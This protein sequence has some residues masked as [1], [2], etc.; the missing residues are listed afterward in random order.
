MKIAVFGNFSWTKACIAHFIQRGHEVMLFFPAADLN[1]YIFYDFD[2]LP[3]PVMFYQD[4]KD[5]RVRYN[6]QAFAPDYL[7]SII[8]DKKVPNSIIELASQMALN[9]HPAKLPEFR[10]GNAWYWPVRLG[11]RES[12][13]TIHKLTDQWDQGDIVFQESFPLDP[14]ET[15][16][17][18][19]DKV[20]RLTP[21]LISNFDP[22][23]SGHNLQTRPQTGEARYFFKP[24]DSDF[25]IHWNNDVDDID[26]LI[27]ASYPYYIARTAWRK[28]Y[29]GIVEA[30]PTEEPAKGFPGEV[31]VST[32]DVSVNCGGQRLLI[33]RFMMFDE[34]VFPA[35][36]FIRR[37]SLKTGETF[38]SP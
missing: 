5:E 13:V 10:S 37:Y 1:H 23:L 38:F 24:K 27:R 34:G 30:E 17:S 25:L 31:D 20:L 2:D 22:L 16:K 4:I 18:Y 3:I 33:R 11:A 9:F 35:Q 6:V 26:A 36:D 12:A 8:L 7:F 29:I 15:I 19:V 32:T 21:Q 14:R 28:K